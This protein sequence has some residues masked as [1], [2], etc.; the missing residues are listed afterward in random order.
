MK[1]IIIQVND[2]TKL[3]YSIDDENIK[4][5]WGNQLNELHLQVKYNEK[6][7]SLGIISMRKNHLSGLI[8]GLQR[9]EKLLTLK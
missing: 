7:F 8:D 2:D 6:W 1:E 3:V 4:D 5:Y 9:L